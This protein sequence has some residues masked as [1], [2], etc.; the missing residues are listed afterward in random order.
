MTNESIYHRLI[1]ITL[2][3]ATVAAL[4]LTGAIAYWHHASVA[5]FLSHWLAGALILLAVLTSFILIWLL[6]AWIHRLLMQ[7][8]ERRE[9]REQFAKIAQETQHLKAQTAI[10]NKVPDLLEQ[11][12]REG[13]HHIEISAHGDVKI[14]PVFAPS[15]AT[16]IR[17]READALPAATTTNYRSFRELIASGTLEQAYRDRKL[18]LGYEATNGQLR[19]GSW[20]DLYSCA[21]AGVS[22]SGKTTTTLFLLYQAVLHGALL[23][24]IDPHMH[25]PDESL[26]ARFRALPAVHSIDDEPRAM[27]HLIQTITDEVAS[28]K[29]TGR[30]TPFLILVVDEFNAVMRALRVCEDDEL[31]SN[32]LLSIA[33]EGRKF[34][35]FAMLIGQRWSHQDIGNANIRSSLASSL[36]HRFT[37]ETQSRLLI[38]G[39]AGSRC[40]DLP[41]GHFL[42]RDTNGNVTEMITPYTEQH[43][44]DQIVSLMSSRVPFTTE[45][46]HRDIMR[47]QRGMWIYKGNERGE[48]EDEGEDE[49]K[50]DILVTHTTITEPVALPSAFHAITKEKRR[51][52]LFTVYQAIQRLHTTNRRALADATGMSIGKVQEL[53]AALIA[54]G[55]IAE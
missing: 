45:S 38:G 51:D 9:R 43:D 17:E 29:R 42:F 36:A 47:E 55:Y 50:D 15:A 30:K 27:R 2:I 1:T 5:D 33:Q 12:L 34:G 31:M 8:Y 3:L 28:R 25:E 53:V 23:R 24:I 6:A 41:T 46:A 37:D 35:I 40:L 22:G 4:L 14:M 18:L 48:E 19:Y 13:M 26:A 10:L 32:L 39:R 44:L 54:Q 16:V 49:G 11:T 7:H 52:D 20:L 21:V